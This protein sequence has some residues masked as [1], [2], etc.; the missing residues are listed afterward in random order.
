[1]F[2]GDVTLSVCICLFSFLT[3]WSCIWEFLFGNDSLKSTFASLM[4]WP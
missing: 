2:I 1:V 3:G 4:P